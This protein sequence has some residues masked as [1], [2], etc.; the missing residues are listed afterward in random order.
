MTMQTSREVRTDLVRALR[1]DLIGPDVAHYPADAAYE[2]ERLPM[3]PSRWYLTGF[4]V[5]RDAP[6]EQRSDETS[7]EEL[8]LAGNADS[9]GDDDATPERGAARRVFL[10]SSLGMSVLVPSGVEA[11]QVTVR[12][13]DYQPEA[14]EPAANASAGQGGSAAKG[15]STAGGAAATAGEGAGQ[16]QP[17][18]EGVRLDTIWRREPREVV[19]S[20]TLPAAG[21]KPTKFPVPGSEGLQLYAHA[22]TTDGPGSALP[23][24]A[25]AVAVFL[26]NERKPAEKEDPDRA[27]AFQASLQLTSPAGFLGRPDPRRGNA[28]DWDDRVADVQY[29]DVLEFAT[30]HN[31][32]CD[33]LAN[34][35]SCSTVWSAWMPSAEVPFTEPARLDGVLLGMEALASATEDQLRA[36]LSPLVDRYGA[37]ITERHRHL[38]SDPARR[39]TAEEL[40]TA[41]ERARNRMRDGIELL[42][43]PQCRRAFQL[44]NAAMADAARHR[45][46]AQRGIAPGAVDPPAWRPFQLAF[47]LLNLSG[48]AK[49]THDDRELVDLLFF[50]TGGGKTEAYLGLA[51]FTLILRR[52]R[53]S[54]VAGAGVSVL[55][56]YTL[57]LLTLDQLGRAAG[58]IC[59][60]E[61]LRPRETDL[62]EWPFEIGLWVGRAATPNRMGERGDQDET[63]A[64][65]RVQKFQQNPKA[66][67]PIPIER[68]PWCGTPFTKESFRLAPNADYPRNLNV[69]CA[70]S[71]CDFTGNRPLPIVAVDE[72]LYR[73][74][75]CFVIATVD[76]FAGLP[77]EARAG[78]LFGLVERHDA[79]GFYGAA[80]PGIGA[81]LPGGRLPPMDLIIQD[82]LHLISGPL[83]TIA[84]LYETAID[85]FASRTVDG[86]RVRPKVIA[87]TA[88]VRRAE[89]QSR[90]LFARRGV[91]LFP[92][93]S[94][95]RGDSF[96]ARTA[97]TEVT[98]PRQYVGVAAPGR[99]LRVVM[100]RVY[101]AMISAA[102]KAYERNGGNASA[103]STSGNPADPYMSLLGYFNALR[104]LGGARRIVEGEVGDRVRNY[105]QRRRVDEAEG[106]YANRE[107]VYEP[108]EL[109]SRVP[110]SEVAAA[111]KRLEETW[112]KGQKERSVDVAL[113]TNMISVGL[114][115]SRLGLMVVLGQPKGS[116]EYIQSTSRV[117]RDPARPGLVITLLTLNKPRDR[118]HFER[119][120]FYHKTFYRSVESTSVTPFAPRAVDRV[121]PAVVAALARH[122]V[123]GL[124]PAKAAVEIEALRSQLG[125][126]SD[127]LAARVTEHDPQMDAAT[128]DALRQ[129]IQG[130]AN[131]LLD[132]WS[133]FAHQ[134]KDVGA[135]LKY[136]K[137]EKVERA[138]PLLRDPLDPELPALKR[139]ERAFKAARSMRDVEP[140]VVLLKKGAD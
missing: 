54:G 121:L 120:A 16:G 5:P 19:L 30:G 4:L 82:E 49:P 123:S 117:G 99:S 78:T 111:K 135:S 25:R 38:P 125:F 35:A 115:I 101:V 72:P 63:T 17:S 108:L 127:V 81:P 29:A 56:R 6:E 57:R 40:L 33:W 39:R 36:G 90:A 133:E 136:Q 134:Q 27:Y 58:L 14:G 116:A 52:L 91:E 77:F 26:V 15:A 34:G 129:K 139:H 106:L 76:K 95:D 11:L 96:F 62:G 8:D 12:W 107:I 128:R 2:R 140:E 114:D 13:G 59:A 84:G 131:E 69:L 31:V 68:C 130:L 51:A 42:G 22:R 104:E 94:P 93:A 89:S 122:G 48:I 109:T 43:D 44:A 41:A 137:Y 100:L 55:M 65:K 102:L 126:I 119:F 1:L 75:P 46:G 110:T 103:A 74:L 9:Q 24:G 87:S 79:E 3:R 86:K 71:R 47:F 66:G 138:M 92:P 60:L 118:S 20:L 28:D 21:A 23:S 112:R 98:A 61:Q 7:Q 88:T 73:R 18:G 70:N 67:S 32:S 80:D 124:T 83:G 113:A 97:S 64:R 105:A 45:E 53:N 50:P 10:P 132:H 37:W 85:H